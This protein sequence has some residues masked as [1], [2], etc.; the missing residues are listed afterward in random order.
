MCPPLL[1]SAYSRVSARGMADTGAAILA[2]YRCGEPQNR[3]QPLG[4]HM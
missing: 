4:F 2:A 3:K 1:L